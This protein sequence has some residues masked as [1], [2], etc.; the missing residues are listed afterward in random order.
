MWS[1][2]S[3]KN[4]RRETDSTFLVLAQAWGQAEFSGL[5]KRQKADSSL[6]KAKQEGK[7]WATENTRSFG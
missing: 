1:V 4:L 6:L 7:Q 5:S 3:Q 2:N